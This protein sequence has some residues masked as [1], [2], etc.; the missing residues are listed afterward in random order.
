MTKIRA[1]WETKRKKRIPFGKEQKKKRDSWA[2]KKEKRE[3]GG[4]LLSRF[5]PERKAG[6]WFA[7][8]LRPRG[9]TLP[10][11][12]EKLDQL[13]DQA[14]RAGIVEEASTSLSERLAQF[15]ESVTRRRL[16]A[17]LVA[18]IKDLI[19]NTIKR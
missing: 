13:R 5:K 6:G 18:Q 12:Y 7:R 4:G 19:S 11:Y 8:L 10:R 15:M 2:T 16:D 1:A 3:S 9:L 17:G 14:E